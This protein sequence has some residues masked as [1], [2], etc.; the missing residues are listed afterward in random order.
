MVN[1]LIFTIF[2]LGIGLVMD[3]D[4]MRGCMGGI[5]EMGRGPWS[6]RPKVSSTKL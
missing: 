6:V 5:E 3:I 4:M 1:K 2:L